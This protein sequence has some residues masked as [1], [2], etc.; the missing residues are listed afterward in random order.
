[1]NFRPDAEMVNPVIVM[2]LKY[3][4]STHKVLDIASGKIMKRI[5][6][7][8]IHMYSMDVVPI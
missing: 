5:C 1:M 4:Y 6:D 2:K 7:N 8:D 3:T